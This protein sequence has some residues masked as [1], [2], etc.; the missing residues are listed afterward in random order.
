MHSFCL[1]QIVMELCKSFKTT[2]IPCSGQ[3][4]GSKPNPHY[5]QHKH[6][7]KSF[8]PINIKEMVLVTEDYTTMSS[9]TFAHITAY[10]FFLCDHGPFHPKKNN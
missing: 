7:H 5:H 9:G 2:N 1:L 8:I 3:P 10:F 4:V 6:F